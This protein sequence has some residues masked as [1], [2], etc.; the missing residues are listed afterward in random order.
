MEIKSI[1]IFY[2]LCLIITGISAVNLSLNTYYIKQQRKKE[3]L[4][5]S[6]L[7]TADQIIKAPKNKAANM[8]ESRK[9]STKNKGSVAIINGVAYW[10]IDGKV[11]SSEID[12]FGEIDV[13]NAK[14]IDA[15]SLSES[16]MQYL[17]KVLDNLNKG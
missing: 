11:F 9:I 13:D 14:T 8:S 5:F 10:K 4:T 7:Q 1:M 15:F 12:E 2:K 6:E 3:F 17:F 16:E